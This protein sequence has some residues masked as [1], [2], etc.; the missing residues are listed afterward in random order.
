M[1]N[2]VDESLIT[3]HGYRE[4]NLQLAK[5]NNELKQQL[6]Q[7]IND[8]ATRSEQIYRKDVEINNLKQQLN[9]LSAI[10][11]KYD[12][13]VDIVLNKASQVDVLSNDKELQEH[14]K[15]QKQRP[16]TESNIDQSDDSSFTTLTPTSDD[17]SSL[18]AEDSGNLT[19]N[20]GDTFSIQGLDRI[21]EH[22]EEQEE[23]GRNESD[24]L[25]QDASKDND[26]PESN[27]TDAY[28]DSL[29][30]PDVTSVPPFA[31]VER[32]IHTPSIWKCLDANASQSVSP[33][34]ISHVLR[35]TTNIQPN[36]PNL[37]HCRKQNANK[38]HDIYHS[39][40][41][42]DGK[43]QS[44][45]SSQPVSPNH[46]SIGSITPIAGKSARE[47]VF[48]PDK[49]GCNI[50]LKQ[51]VVQDQPQTMISASSKKT[52]KTT[53]TKRKAVQREVIFTNPEPPRY[54]L[55][56]RTKI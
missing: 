26:N 18:T 29:D 42:Q 16:Q 14:Q 31:A 54:N 43:A 8:N 7:V 13:I 53:G 46:A 12:S 28:N 10:K 30:P 39:T 25:L 22:S 19:S 20:L 6:S 1:V 40:P 37:S 55:R 56:K 33:Q 52:T 50:H 21:S 23:E 9:E 35:I 51:T 15:K 27:K 49:S 47:T 4:T 17:I 48:I 11:Q 44:Y 34:E 2:V 24:S 41:V 38:L 3:A 45:Q 5:E 32:V 36:S